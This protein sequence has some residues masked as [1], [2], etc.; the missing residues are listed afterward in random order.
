MEIWAQSSTYEINIYL[1]PISHTIPLNLKINLH[2]PLEA[3]V[4]GQSLSDL[5]SLCTG[6]KK[7]PEDRWKI[8]TRKNAAMIFAFMF[9][10][11]YG[12]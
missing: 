8:V 7:R 1:L 5:H 3:D 11:M 9:E 4:A 10:V 6:P 2:I 12:T